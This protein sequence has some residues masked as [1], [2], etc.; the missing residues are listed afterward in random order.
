MADLLRV[1]Q[2]LHWK[3][4]TLLA[5]ARA[6]ATLGEQHLAETGPEVA[7]QRPVLCAD[8]VQ[9]FAATAR[10]GAYP[11]LQLWTVQVEPS[12]PLAIAFPIDIFLELCPLYWEM[13]L[14]EAAQ[15]SWQQPGFSQC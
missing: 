2:V 14:A 3:W 11:V 7:G 4:A 10:S 13:S 15:I 5:V 12:R 1:Q 9:I 6:A 8:S